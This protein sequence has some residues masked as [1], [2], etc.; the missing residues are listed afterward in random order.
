MEP[1]TPWGR[2]PNPRMENR[3]SYENLMSTGSPYHYSHVI[4]FSVRGAG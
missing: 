3:E 1:M 2:S 4:E